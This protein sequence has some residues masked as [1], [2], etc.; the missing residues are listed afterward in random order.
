MSGIIRGLGDYTQGNAQARLLR[1]QAREAQR[2]AY[3][4][5]EALRREA[6]QV[7]GAQAAAMAQSGTGL[8]GTNEALVRQSAALAELDALNIRYRGLTQA[9]ALRAEAKAAKRAGRYSLFA[10]IAQTALS[11]GSGGV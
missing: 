9:K 10:G 6:R 4:D 2:Q 7:L 3:A 1:A 11:S 8:G 5:E